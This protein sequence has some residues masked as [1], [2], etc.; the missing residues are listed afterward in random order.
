MKLSLFEILMYMQGYNI[1]VDYSKIINLKKKSFA[2]YQEWLLKKK[3]DI[4]NY[5]FNNN[6][7]YKG[8]ISHEL[9][10]VWEKLP[11]VTKGNL[12]NDIRSII[13][14]NIK[15][16]NLY[17]S[18]TSG[19]SG[20]PF[21][22]AKDKRAHARAWAYW[23]NRYE[24][25]GLSLNS[26]EARF[27]GIPKDLKGYFT[28]K[29]RDIVLNRVRFPIFDLSDNVMMEFVK[30]FEKNKFEYIYGYTNSIL[31]LANYLKKNN[32]NLKNI[33]PSL[34][35]TIVTSEVCESND[36]RKIRDYIGAPVKNE[37]GASE[38]GYIAYECDSNIWHVCKEN[39]FVEHDMNGN[40]LITDLFNKA[41]PIIRYAIG[42]IGKVVQEVCN[43]GKE[44]ILIV[45]FDGRRNDTIKLPSGAISPGLTFYYISRSILESSGY[46][47]E[48]IIRQ[49]SLVC[50]EFDIVS[51][52]KI[53]KE[54]IKDL[55][56]KMNQY[57]EPGLDLKVNLVKKINRPSIGK[58]KHF[59][60]EIE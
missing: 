39:I 31:L 25:L 55:K 32:L 59:Y 22:F 57:L 18:N 48:F 30:K 15:I 53:E 29:I 4:V 7:F 42:D 16:N 8:L 46:I 17:I 21:Y 12:Q 38:I 19:S 49:T 35:L 51:D 37:Y 24:D 45:D 60:S 3:W 6:N 14:E 26:K 1:N 47:K 28:E 50:F 2:G 40:I 23:K 56:S 36:R 20:H 54:M 34:K 43:C 13:P 11:K 33:C 5:H 27:Y 52:K 58:I 10:N 9:P 44:D 41:Y